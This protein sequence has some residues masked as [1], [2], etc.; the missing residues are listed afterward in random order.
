MLMYQI[1]VEKL[2]QPSY[3]E[4]LFMIYEMLRNYWTRKKRKQMCYHRDLE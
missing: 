2:F 1:I 3:I 4:I